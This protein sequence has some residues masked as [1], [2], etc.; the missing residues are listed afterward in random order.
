MAPTKDYE[1]YTKFINDAFSEEKSE[2][3]SKTMNAWTRT[4][5]T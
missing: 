5:S 3:F 2:L 4:N 1:D